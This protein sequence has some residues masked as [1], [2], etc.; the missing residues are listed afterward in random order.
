L[1]TAW[2]SDSLMRFVNIGYHAVLHAYSVQSRSSIDTVASKDD[3]PH[4][5]SQ[6]ISEAF[7]PYMSLWVESQ[8]K[9]VTY[10]YKVITKLTS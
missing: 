5:F 4:G 10:M 9:Y 8:D 2:K 1:S 7:E 6:A 3:R